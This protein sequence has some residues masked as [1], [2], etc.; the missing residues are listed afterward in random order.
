[1][2]G[3]IRQGGTIVLRSFASQQRGLIS[4]SA[5]RRTAPAWA[6]E[7]RGRRGA[8]LFSEL[9]DSMTVYAGGA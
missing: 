3:Q 8:H 7:S 6:G 9:L 4:T 1:M 2:D 5:G